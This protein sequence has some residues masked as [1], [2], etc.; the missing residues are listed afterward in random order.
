[1]EQR[2]QRELTFTL[3]LL[4]RMRI[5]A[6]FM[7]PDDDLAVVDAGLRSSIGMAADYEV[8]HHVS[9]HQLRERTIHQMLDQFMC[10]YLYLQ[11]P[12]AE[13]PTALVV[14][15]Y[16][17]ADPSPK[18][19]MEKV[20]QLALPLSAVNVLTEYY[21]SLPIYHD[22]TVIMAV[23]TT[24]GEKLWG[25]SGFDT[26]DMNYEQRSS[27]PGNVSISAPIEQENIL[28]RMQQME[29]RYAYE[30]ELMD[31]VSKG[32]TN[33]AE[34]IMSSVS[35]LNYQPRVPDPLRNQKNYCII[36]NTLLRKAAQQGGVHPY[37]L[38]KLSS[39]YAR[40]IENAPTL[41]IANKLISDMIR[42]YC[43]LVRTQ[44][45]ER[46]SAIIERAR[47]YIDSNLSGDLSLGV[48]AS[49]LQVTPS[50]LSALFHRETGH[51]L[52]G[53]IS[54]QRMKAA[55]QLLVTTRLQVQTVAQLSGFTDP[56][57]FSK[58]FK[59]HYGSTPVQYRQGQLGAVAHQEE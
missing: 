52:A 57:Y 4:E 11:L 36:C 59:Q 55:R 10:H 54:M 44:T 24:L 46:H 45:R 18:D 37:H 42:A 47:T 49:L 48:L 39:H 8:L 14:G 2:Y 21:A 40:L 23:V 51:T 19:I 9:A 29:E 15:P 13:T 17:T 28:L 27:L 34:I 1:M 16:L 26:V 31:I 58:C 7:H 32:L 41:E 38:D 3:S 56:N 25:A 5:P 22:P 53:Y 33:R 35:Q 12:N 6:R 50:Y 30:N 43:R 20:E